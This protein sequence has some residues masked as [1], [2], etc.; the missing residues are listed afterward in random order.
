M[1]RLLARF[2]S[3]TILLLIFFHSIDAQTYFQKANDVGVYDFSSPSLFEFKKL[4]VGSGHTDLPSG[5]YPYGYVLE[6]YHATNYGL[7]LYIP[8]NTGTMYF[9]TGWNDLGTWREVLTA[10]SY[11]AVLDTRYIRKTGGVY[12]GDL[13][14]NKAG[15]SLRLG[16]Y[17]SG[18][19]SARIEFSDF[20]N[21]I[22]DVNRGVYE[23]LR[24]WDA[25]RGD[26]LFLSNASMSLNTRSDIYL[27]VNTGFQ[28]SFGQSIK[29][30][31]ANDGNVGIG[32]SN[33]QAHHG[34]NALIVSGPSAGA[35]RGI[36]EL[37]DGI[38]GKSV[39]Q[40]VYGDTYIGQL[41]KGSG[42][43]KLILLTG[44]S[45]SGPVDAM[46]IDESG[47][48]VLKGS[49]ESQKIKVTASPGSFPDYVF[50]DGYKLQSLEELEAFITTN[51]HLPNVPIAKEVEA[52]GQDLGLIQRKLLEKIEEL[53]LHTIEQ[54]KL[55]RKLTERIE[56]LES[57]D[58]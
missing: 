1:T 21:G 47:N 42:T 33:P 52:N 40:N 25:G 29:F 16:E 8:E 7:Q 32:T 18:G 24:S 26:Y 44:G 50:S 13:E 19:G 9:R 10:D 57:T 17:S 43:G 51:G 2:C 38:T 28:Y 41:E 53:T 46:I 27:G 48:A 22:L 15:A 56:K 14:I 34:S 20:S 58:N 45:G 23:F 30:V 5:A 49:F 39:F 36:I 35:T 3:S 31:I 37:W 11:P 54:E 12:T 6:M 4:G 55:I